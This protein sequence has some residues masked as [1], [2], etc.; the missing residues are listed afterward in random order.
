MLLSTK[1]GIGIFGRGQTVV[2][3]TAILPANPSLVSVAPRGRVFVQITLRQQFPKA[4]IELH[5]VSSHAAQPSH[6]SQARRRLD[7]LAIMSGH[8]GL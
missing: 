7:S 4:R 2:C 3:S 1:L 5:N 8:F 6:A